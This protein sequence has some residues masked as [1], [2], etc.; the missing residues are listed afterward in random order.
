MNNTSVHAKPKRLKRKVAAAVRTLGELEAPE[1]VKKNSFYGRRDTA[2]CRLG[3][4]GA[5]QLGQDESACWYT[6]CHDD[7]AHL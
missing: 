1:K 4:D 2:S 3:Q 5:L 7:R 6:S